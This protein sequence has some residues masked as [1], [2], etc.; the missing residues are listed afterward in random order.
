MRYA[1]GWNVPTIELPTSGSVLTDDP[2]LLPGPG[3]HDYT[4]LLETTWDDSCR[5]TEAGGG[6]L[7]VQGLGTHTDVD[8]AWKHWL[9]G[10]HSFF[11]IYFL[12][13]YSYER[14]RSAALLRDLN[15]LDV[16]SGHVIAFWQSAGALM[17]YCL[18]FETKEETY[19]THIRPQMPPA[20]S[21]YWCREAASVHAVTAAW[22]AAVA[23]SQDPE[24][25]AVDA[26]IRQAQQA[27][28][29]YHIRAMAVVP[30]GK[31][32]AE[33]ERQKHGC[34]HAITDSDFAQYDEWFGVVR[35]ASQTKGDFLRAAC[36][37]FAETMAVIRAGHHLSNG[38]IHHI[39]GGIR[40]AIQIFEGWLRPVPKR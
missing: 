3:S 5:L 34:R 24:I 39:A 10:H 28:S 29:S 11:F 17:D 16:W 2:R 20:F 1:K 15:N 22:H 32:L 23:A 27:Y 21:G 31:S 18:D 35:T 26:K 13:A 12:L 37:T 38:S 40:A 19:S 33:V 6:C 36:G 9:Q 8:Q 30:E 25:A 14:S 4:A 7:R